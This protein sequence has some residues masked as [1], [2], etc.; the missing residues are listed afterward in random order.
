M[1]KQEETA[2]TVM[3]RE[4]LVSAIADAIA[5]MEGFRA[6]KTTLAFRNANPGNIMR[7][8]DKNDRPYPDYKGYVDFVAWAKEKYPDLPEEEQRELGLNEGWRVLKKVI[9]QYIDGRYHGGES[10]TLAQMFAKYA[11]KGH[12]DN[13]PERYAA[14]V[15]EVVGIPVDVPLKSLIG[16]APA[17]EGGSPVLSVVVPPDG[18]AKSDKTFT[19]PR[20]TVV[21]PP[22]SIAA[23]PKPPV[24]TP[25]ESAAVAPPVER[26]KVTLPGPA[27]RQYEEDELA[28]Y[29]AMWLAGERGMFRHPLDPD[30][31]VSYAQVLANPLLLREKVT[32]R[33]LNFVP[34]GKNNEWDE[35]PVNVMLRAHAIAAQHVKQTMQDKTLEEVFRAYHDPDLD[36][37]D[38]A[39]VAKEF[40]TRLNIDPSKPLKDY[41]EQSV[42]EKYAALGEA[43]L[44]WGLAVGKFMPP[45]IFVN[46]PTKDD[47]ITAFGPLLTLGAGMGVMAWELVK[48][49]K[50]WKDFG[51]ELDVEG[52]KESFKAK[53]EILADIVS[54]G[55]YSYAKEVSEGPADIVPATLHGMMRS[56]VLLDLADL[57]AQEKKSGGTKQAGAFAAIGLASTIAPLLRSGR[58]RVGSALHKI[59]QDARVLREAMPDESVIN[60]LKG[61]DKLPLEEPKPVH[62]VPPEKE[63]RPLVQEAKPAAEGKLV[64]EVKSEEVKL[65]QEAKPAQEV[66]PEEAKPVEEVKPEEVKPAEEVKPEEVKLAEEGKLEE[67]GKLAQEAKPEE[68]KLAQEAKPE[69]ETK[70]AQ[71][72]KPEEVKLEEGK[73][74]EEGKPAEEA[75]PVDP[76]QLLSVASGVAALEGSLNVFKET[77]DMG[78]VSRV[79]FRSLEEHPDLL[80]VIQA[81]HSEGKPI[82]YSLADELAKEP[83]FLETVQRHVQKAYKAGELPAPYEAAKF[84]EAGKGIIHNV[85]KNLSYLGALNKDITRVSEVL[86]DMSHAVIQRY[87]VVRHQRSF[88]KKFAEVLGVYS[89]EELGHV[90]ASAVGRVEGSKR[91]AKMREALRKLGLPDEEVERLTDTPEFV[92]SVGMDKLH[93]IKSA[94]V[95]KVVREAGSN[96]YVPLST[97]IVGPDPFPG[98]P[99]K[100]VPPVLRGAVAWKRGDVGAIEK[101]VPPPQQG[102]PVKEV[103]EAI[104]R[105][106]LRAPSRFNTWMYTLTA[107]LQNTSAGM[108]LSHFRTASRNLISAFS[109]AGIEIVSKAM[110]GAAGLGFHTEWSKG[111]LREAIDDLS[112]FVMGGKAREGLFDVMDKFP[113]VR[114]IIQRSNWTLERALA[115]NMTQY[116]TPA[117]HK[118]LHYAEIIAKAGSIANSASD[119]IAKTAITATYAE[120]MLRKMGVKPG[121][122]DA[123]RR[124]SRLS[125]AAADPALYDKLAQSLAYA[126]RKGQ[127][128]TFTMDPPE[129]TL[130][131]HGLQLM[132]RYPILKLL[133]T[134]F[135]RFVYNSV[136]WFMDHQFTNAFNLLDP[137]YRQ[138]LQ[139]TDPIKASL[140]HKPL[141]D[142]IGGFMMLSLAYAQLERQNPP[143]YYQIYIGKDKETGKDMYMDYRNLGP[144]HNFAFMAHMARVM[145]G[146]TPPNLT[147]NEVLNALTSLSRLDDQL[148]T[149]IEAITRK[150]AEAGEGRAVDVTDVLKELAGQ[151]IAPFGKPIGMV[152]KDIVQP[153][154]QMMGLKEDNA[155]V[156]TVG[157]PSMA[158]VPID[159]SREP[160]AK[161][162]TPFLAP[163]TI[164]KFIGDPA[165]HVAYMYDIF[166]EKEQPYVGSMT[167]LGRGL[168]V[169][170]FKV[171]EYSPLQHA[172]HKLGAQPHEYS[173]QFFN[174][175][176][177]RMYNYRMTLV[178]DSPLRINGKP[179]PLAKAIFGEW[180]PSKFSEKVMADEK[181]VSVGDAVGALMLDEEYQKYVLDRYNKQ[182]VNMGFEGVDAKAIPRL[183]TGYFFRDVVRIADSVYR[184]SEGLANDDMSLPLRGMTVT[185]SIEM[186]YKDSLDEYFKRKAAG[187]VPPQFLLGKPKVDHPERIKHVTRPI[188]S[189][190]PSQGDF[191]AFLDAWDRVTM[192]SPPPIAVGLGAGRIFASLLVKISKIDMVDVSKML[193]KLEAAY[194]AAVEANPRSG[195]VLKTIDKWA[196]RASNQ[197]RGYLTLGAR[198][199]IERASKGINNVLDGLAR[200]IDRYAA[201]TKRRNEAR[202]DKTVAADAMSESYLTKIGKTRKGAGN[203]TQ[204]AYQ[205]TV[206]ASEAYLRSLRTSI[207]NAPEIALKSMDTDPTVFFR[208]VTKARKKKN[209]MAE[210]QQLSEMVKRGEKVSDA[211]FLVKVRIL[212]NDFTA[213]E[214]EIFMKA[215]GVSPEEYKLMAGRT[216]KYKE[217]KWNKEQFKR[218]KYL[219]GLVAV[220]KE[221]MD[222]VIADSLRRAEKEPKYPV[223]EK[224]LRKAR[225]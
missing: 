82:S 12:G 125:V 126:L 81:I 17:E 4:A 106:S 194:K 99:T 117:Q 136:T 155:W 122:D 66:K 94:D 64:Q 56:A 121:V 215:A 95:P 46:P 50:V 58:Y 110:A 124:I 205:G 177:N 37:W 225:P 96:P 221:R 38:P 137:K 62:P 21:I 48:P 174:V 86:R 61:K 165:D 160:L 216:W 185:E 198:G 223:S 105:D 222:E 103:M 3:P 170:G 166:G 189:L 59:E 102:V 28:G 196:V 139:S 210:L 45:F 154:V 1:P 73:P 68:V 63:V 186:D 182:V 156:Q 54:L 161:A 129:N 195:V 148:I 44:N 172:L 153:F 140:A 32:G 200:R 91:V 208:V 53:G 26:M 80:P 113:G 162:L 114:A 15:A 151:I 10:P 123:G 128:F 74:V 207:E 146:K 6:K 191:E 90:A 23:A 168:R 193:P 92:R 190:M 65:A 78:V 147:A 143:K 135:P 57:A 51:K 25:P 179:S 67:E 144:Y 202:A 88:F 85:A 157:P 2:K 14:F 30:R 214:D 34:P 211:K 5:T 69:E 70:P 149:K 87:D 134:N 76:K 33:V 199:H 224:I 130:V 41:V 118:L 104:E 132:T 152:V 212:M 163:E 159:A 49:P 24:A 203:I 47:A 141:L 173:K 75:K 184:V 29:I 97:V 187:P 220:L 142:S 83:V 35:H 109:N 167:E 192:A 115:A 31:P 108:S 43:T 18:G 39:L 209:A 217:Q 71:E 111:L 127:E 42:G 27:K 219:R 213:K 180:V 89:D 175:P 150:L 206:G 176:A 77:L 8:R 188:A 19:N 158:Q 181:L 13:D 60:I 22:G 138:L 204:V 7:W 52:M 201:V 178:M 116:M 145:E 9:N 120:N 16:D 20:F 100:E 171:D 93:A 55:G 164:N 79:L 101:L 131:A 218:E 98:V 169:F 197:V 11:P 36:D 72:I 107:A 112:V 40:G 133:T 183:M 119:V 84:L